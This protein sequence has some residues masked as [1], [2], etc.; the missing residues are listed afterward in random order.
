MQ[1]VALDTYDLGLFI[2]IKGDEKYGAV[3][4]ID[5]SYLVFGLFSRFSH[6]PVPFHAISVPEHS[7]IFFLTRILA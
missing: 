3:S 4:E 7:R 5:G 6:C 1:E 2:D